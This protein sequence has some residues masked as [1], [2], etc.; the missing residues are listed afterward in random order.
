MDKGVQS[1]TAKGSTAP[2]QV[3]FDAEATIDV[4]DI[5]EAVL[6]WLSEAL[7]LPLPCIRSAASKPDMYKYGRGSVVYRISDT[8]AAMY[9]KE[10]RASCLLRLAV[11]AY[12]LYT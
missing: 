12:I 9:E 11:T 2:F 3:G 6:L 10:P 8:Y 7:S 4:L 5:F 1:T